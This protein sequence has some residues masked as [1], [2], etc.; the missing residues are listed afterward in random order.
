MVAVP[1]LPED[2]AYYAQCIARGGYFE[3]L[4]I[5]AEDQERGAL[6]AAN[7]ERDKL[8]DSVTDMD[9]YLAAL[10]T[11]LI[12]QPFD[13][14]GLSRIVQLA[15]KTNQFNLTTTRYVDRDIERAIADPDALTLQLRAKDIYGDNGVISLIVGR[16]SGADLFV[17]T[18]LMSCRVLGRQVEQATLNLLVERAREIGARQIVGEYRPTAKNG[19]V[20]DHYAKLGFE[21]LV[22]EFGAA[23]VT[24]WVLNIDDFQPTP[25]AITTLK[26]PHARSA[27]DLHSA[28]RDFS[29]PVR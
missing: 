27:A 25:T 21:P 11:E 12:W 9:S 17:E 8:R 23:G 29:G 22:G 2:P 7:A 3:A 18:W 24:R 19:M 16:R 13:K 4:S 15:N 14:L 20:R 10:N 6:Y 1:E 5:T 26:G 28:Q